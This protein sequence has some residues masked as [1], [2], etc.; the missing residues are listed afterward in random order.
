[1]AEAPRGLGGPLAVA[2]KTG[3]A[4][5]VIT[6]DL[7]GLRMRNT[8]PGGYA[9]VQLSLA[10]GARLPLS[11]DPDE[12]DYYGRVFA[13]DTR[14]GE[15]CGEG[16]IEDLGRSSDA[17]GQTWDVT[18]IGPSAHAEDVTKPYI[19][20][21]R[22]N[23]AFKPSAINLQYASWMQTNDE[24]DPGQGLR[25][26]VPQGTTV[27]PT[28]KVGDVIYQMIGAAGQTIARVV[29][30]V[31]IGFTD[32]GW[33]AEII[34]KSSPTGTAHL[35]GSFVGPGSG[36]PPFQTTVVCALDTDGGGAIVTGDSYV[37]FRADH[38]SGAANTIPDTLCWMEFDNWYIKA[39]RQLKDG[40]TKTS[41][42]S[43]ATLT[44]DTI[45]E[46]ILP[47]FLP[48]Y[49]G[50]TAVVTAGGYDLDQFA[51][52]DG[53]TAKKILDDL[54]TFEPALYWAAWESNAAGKNRFEWVP[55]PTQVAYE[56]DLMFEDFQAPST[57]ADLYDKVLVRYLATSG[58]IKTVTRTQTVPQLT[59]AG[60]SRQGWIDLG[61]EVGSTANATRAGDQFLAER[62]YPAN[63]GSI[64]ISR[65]LVNLLTGLV[66]W[67]HQIKSGRLIRVRGI[68][69]NTDSLN[70]GG[71][72]RDGVTVF[73]I[74]SAEWDAETGS[75]QCELDTYS[76][77]VATA[78]A[79]FARRPRVRRR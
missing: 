72:A 20:L 24:Q 67:P 5:R 64:T 22:M 62:K 27:P 79:D 68:D 8:A 54:M 1:M 12:L 39:V 37:T 25:V 36:T 28:T 50:A 40:T 35:A 7:S 51:Y 75:V 74:K 15:V 23:T 49:D 55:W 63:A 59:A 38:I 70:P 19:V 65:P 13:F 58:T 34:T 48:Q 11:R 33:R 71:T 9:S 60:L 3:R 46:D 18:A 16:R 73:K 57:A 31:T 52:Y 56:A 2:V 21:D 77:S 41:G 32:A 43:G 26:Y 44:S 66:E 17:D 45:V 10:N 6:D 30:D 14:T 61:D 47:K 78:L 76:R 4:W 29:V 69:P 42:Y 53:V